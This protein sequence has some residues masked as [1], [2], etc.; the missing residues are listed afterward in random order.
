MK[1]TVKDYDNGF[2]PATSYDIPDDLTL[3]DIFNV[4]INSNKLI[5]FCHA[6]YANDIR[7][8]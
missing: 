4:D 1:L 8:Q 7:K 5:G 6:A 3:K 2:F